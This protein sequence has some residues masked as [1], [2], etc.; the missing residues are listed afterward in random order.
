MA[1]ANR[2][3]VKWIDNVKSSHIEAY[4]ISATV[5][6]LDADTP[7][8]KTLQERLEFVSMWLGMV[9]SRTTAPAV[10]GNEQELCIRDYEHKSAGWVKM[11]EE[12]RKFLHVGQY[13]SEEE[14]NSLL[15][16]CKP[17]DTTGKSDKEK[18][19]AMA[20]FAEKMHARGFNDTLAAMSDPPC[21]SP[22]IVMCVP[23]FQRAINEI[24]KVVNSAEL[25]QN[26]TVLDEQMVQVKQFKASLLTA[27]K[28][29]RSRSPTGQGKRKKTRTTE[30]RKKQRRNNL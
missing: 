6:V 29:S 24:T 22:D 2:D 20:E 4:T 30:R 26:I 14:K 9:V 3:L 25:D 1:K 8:K 15:A 16:L 13:G 17:P 23:A 12:C 7:F 28:D 18:K 27:A 10:S 19:S 21:K 5:L 11:A